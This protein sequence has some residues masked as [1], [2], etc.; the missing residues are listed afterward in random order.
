[1]KEKKGVPRVYPGSDLEK[2]QAKFL[3]IFEDNIGKIRERF[4]SNP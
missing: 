4:Q 1:M 2:V 3:A